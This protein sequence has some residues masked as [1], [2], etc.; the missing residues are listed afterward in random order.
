MVG[1]RRSSRHEAKNQPI[2]DPEPELPSSTLNHED[3]SS[4]ETIAATLG[5]PVIALE[6]N[7][8][9][10]EALTA[11][12]SDPGAEE[13]AGNQSDSSS[14]NEKCP[15]CPDVPRKAKA[16]ESWVACEGCQQWY[17]W[18]CVGERGDLATID[19]WYVC[20]Y[21]ILVAAIT[22]HAFFPG[23]ASHVW[24]QIPPLLLQ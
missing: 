19:K 7:L 4:T 18:D 17:H 11:T 13:D 6:I 21:S 12:V 3:S 23:I 5:D 24:H 15:A 14:G 16:K 8:P 2:P 22:Y 1:T 9:Q 20:M 10:E